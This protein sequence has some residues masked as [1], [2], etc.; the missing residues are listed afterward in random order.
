[1]K[2]HKLPENANVCF[3]ELNQT[4]IDELRSQRGEQTYTYETIQDQILRRDLSFILD[5][6]SD[7][8]ELLKRVQSIPEIKA[9]E[10]FDLYQGENL[11][12]GKKS[13]SI[14]IKFLGDGTMTTEQ[15]NEVM[16]KAIKKAESVGAKLRE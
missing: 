7:F 16:E 11:P 15:I 6:K 2:E 14:K 4:M 9:V 8:S 1:M 10:V 12:E 13:L 5:E 3:V